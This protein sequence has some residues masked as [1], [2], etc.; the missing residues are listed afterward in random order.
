MYIKGGK[1]PKAEVRKQVYAVREGQFREGRQ[2][3]IIQLSVAYG[4]TWD[5]LYTTLRG[6]NMNKGEKHLKLFNSY[7][8]DPLWF[9]WIGR[10]IWQ[11]AL[12]NDLCEL[13]KDVAGYLQG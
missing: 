11:I 2:C 12:T 13:H 7:C 9:G 5:E 3:V 1:Y 10:I 4:V 6:H 8:V